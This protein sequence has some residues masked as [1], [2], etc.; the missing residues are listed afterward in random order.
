MPTERHV[1]MYDVWVFP[2]H[3]SLC[4]A[5]PDLTAAVLSSLVIAALPN[6]WYH[7]INVV[8]SPV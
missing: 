2:A 7:R 8:N 5:L 4:A 3:R 6:G 1:I